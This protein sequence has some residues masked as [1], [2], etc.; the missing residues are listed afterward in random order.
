MP[1]REETIINLLLQKGLVTPHQIERAR[2]EVKRTGFSFEKALEKLGFI[3]E[4]DL[5][6]IHAESMGVM[7]VNLDD[8]LIDPEVTKLISEDLARKYKMIP[9]FR[10]GDTL[11]VA[12]ANPK[13]IVALD[14]VRVRSKIN[15][16]EPALSTERQ[17][18]KAIEEYYGVTG[19]VEDIM[20]TIDGGRFPV[21]VSEEA[22]V[23]QLAKEAEQAP[24]V[25]LVN[26]MITEAVKDNAS[27]IHI[28]PEADKLR[29]RHRVDGILYE[30]SILPKHLQSVVASRI[31]ILAKMDIAETRRP[32]DGRMQLKMENKRLDVRVSSFP[33]I[34]G[35]NIVMRILDRSSMFRSLKE[36]GF[37]E[38]E[39][40]EYER[41]IRYPY[42][43]ILVTGP[44][45][46]GKTTTLYASLATINSMEVNIITIEDPVEY[47][48][49]LVRQTQVNP[50]AG[51][52]FA[53]S[54]RA[55]LRQDPDVVMVGE[56]RDK[57]TAEI[58]VQASLT[59][60]LVFSTLHTNDAPSSLVRL[61]DMGVEPFLIST[62]IIGIAA[63][64]LVRVIC[65]EC[66][67]S[68]PLQAELVKDLGLKE[69]A[70]FY[71][72]SGCKACKNTGYAGRMGIFEVMPMTEP[73]KKLIV[74]RPSA[75]VIRAKAREEGVRSL[76][77]DGMDK[78]KRGITTIEEVLRVT[79]VV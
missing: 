71:R 64:R 72:G 16:I 75:D 56:V 10:I 48:F 23:K 5:V 33:T 68:Y 32:Q 59:G 27:D 67:I 20:K 8:Y 69:A 30:T 42:G 17:I 18:M 79:E 3:T 46:S 21:V 12:M 74:S 22:E 77:E 38:K 4:N 40:K 73:I 15:L 57:E 36:L 60:H 9:L 11:T 58:A 52:T 76:R 39:Y 43:I 47:E 26:L 13:D 55:I 7:Y 37:E 28:E 78:A 2:E 62:S 66:K 14:E 50:K 51:L 34:H 65:N 53:S 41:I 25:K 63:Q 29:V 31:K 44:T 6:N 19:S 49:P 61:V 45:G 35:E 54:L 24:V 1:G 70:T